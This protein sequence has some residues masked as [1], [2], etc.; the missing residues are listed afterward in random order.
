MTKSDDEELEI[1]RAYEKGK[2]RSVASKN[3]LA[4]FKERSSPA[5]STST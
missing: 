3:E 1:L 2:L 5:F 4:K